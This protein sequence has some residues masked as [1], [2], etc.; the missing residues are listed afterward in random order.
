[1]EGRGWCGGGGGGGGREREGG[2][3]P[4]GVQCSVGEINKV[5]GAGRGAIGVGCLIGDLLTSST[6][7]AGRGGPVPQESCLPRHTLSTCP[8]S[9]WQGRGGGGGRVVLS[10]PELVGGTLVSSLPPVH[11]HT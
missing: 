6:R 7:P 9:C 11:R 10:S 4:A 5:V 2:L 3:R 8:G 1:M